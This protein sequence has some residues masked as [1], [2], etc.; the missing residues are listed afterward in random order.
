MSDV[1]RCVVSLT[2]VIVLSTVADVLYIFTGH[3]VL[4]TL[5]SVLILLP[6]DFNFHRLLAN[7]RPTDRVSRRRSPCV[8]SESDRPSRRDLWPFH[9]CCASRRALPK[10]RQR[11]R[12]KKC[13]N[14]ISKKS[15]VS[16]RR[17]RVFSL[18][19]LCLTPIYRDLNLQTGSPA[20]CCWNPTGR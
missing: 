19:Y 12:S 15:S 4:I 1:R 14:L 11:N 13:S 3:L 20:I 9:R 6:Y 16:M 2:T 8:Q 10:L 18:S 17:R 7:T 5:W